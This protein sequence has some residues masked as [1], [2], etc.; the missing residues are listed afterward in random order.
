MDLRNVGAGCGWF[1]ERNTLSTNVRTRVLVLS[2][3]VQS[4]TS[5]CMSVIS[6]L[7]RVHGWIP[8]THWL[9]SLAKMASFQYSE[10]RCLKAIKQRIIKTLTLPSVLC[11][12]TNLVHAPSVR[13]MHASYP[14]TSSSRSPKSV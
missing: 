10:R 9:T 6:L 12:C 14:C 13:Y 1:S 11:M 5:L 4:Q 3:H 2:T 8:R 7:G